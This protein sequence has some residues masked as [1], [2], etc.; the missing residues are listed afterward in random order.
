MH[1]TALGS[2]GNMN[3]NEEALTVSGQAFKNSSE[4][5]SQISLTHPGEGELPRSSNWV[6]IQGSSRL[7]SRRE[8]AVDPH[9]LEERCNT[10]YNHLDDG[11]AS[12]SHQWSHH[13]LDGPKSSSKK[14]H[15]LSGKES[16][17]TESVS[18]LTSAYEFSFD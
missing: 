5:R 11:E 8:T 9:W 10:R 3:V 4:S 15:Q 16:L 18:I 14:D 7:N 1:P 12:R 2:S 13:L 17:M 6:A